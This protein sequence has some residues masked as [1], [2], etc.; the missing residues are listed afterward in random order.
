M[1]DLVEPQLALR[2]WLRV[3]KTDAI[4]GAC[5]VWHDGPN[6]L[7]DGGNSFILAQAFSATAAVAQYIAL[8]V[9]GTSVITTAHGDTTLAT[10]GNTEI[11]TNG[12]GR[13]AATSNSTTTAQNGFG[14]NGI[15]TLSKTFTYTGSVQQYVG[16]CGLFNAASVG[17]MV[18]ETPF[19]SAGTVNNNGDTIAVTWTFTLT[20]S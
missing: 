17:T 13:A 15:Q 12:L 8:A 20:G 19:G 7:V 4:T 2:G 10:S 14:S 1:S 18:F 6:H 5:E 11:T 9:N 16:G 3:V